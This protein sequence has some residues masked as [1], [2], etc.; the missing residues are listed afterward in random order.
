MRSDLGGNLTDSDSKVVI[1]RFL[2]YFK[3]VFT[4]LCDDKTIH[5]DSS[6]WQ[7]L[8]QWLLTTGVYYTAEYTAGVLTRERRLK[9][10][11]VLNYITDINRVIVWYQLWNT[12]TYVRT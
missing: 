9:P 3:S 5:G 1:T 8:F 6:D 2:D 10:S 12:G 11:T 4:D 7:A